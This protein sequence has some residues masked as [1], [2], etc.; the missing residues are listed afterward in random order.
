LPGVDCIWQADAPTSISA[1][2]LPRSSIVQ[3]AS[4]RLT[5]FRKNKM[6]LLF[7]TESQTRTSAGRWWRCK[8]ATG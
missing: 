8:L 6:I 1:A 2:M 3:R 4:L 7:K 5:V